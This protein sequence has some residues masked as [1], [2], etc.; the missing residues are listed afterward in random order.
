IITAPEP[1][2]LVTS[3]AIA[4]IADLET[5]LYEAPFVQKVVSI[6]D[7]IALMHQRLF[8]TPDG[9][10][11]TA[12][13]APAQYMLLYEAS[14]DPGDFDQEIDYDYQ[15]ALVR[16]Q[17]DRDHYSEVRDSVDAFN[18]IA[19]DWS[20]ESGL[21][22]R[23]SGR[24][25][26]NDGW[27]TSLAQGHGVSLGLA[28]AF[29]FTATL[30][31]Y[32]DARLSLITLAPVLSGV[33]L[34]YA[35]MGLLGIAIAPATSM[36]AAI[37]TG[38]GVDFGVHLVQEIRRKLAAGGDIADAVGEQYVLIARACAYCAASLA[39]G[40][41]VVILSGVPVLRWFGILVASATVGSLL[42]ALFVVPALS[43]LLLNRRAT[44]VHA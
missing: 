27:M 22:A 44:P 43:S 23:V 21:T 33:A 18:D 24:L 36:C 19:A 17:L 28:V 29:V 31:L 11:P 13:N 1:E 6:A 32:R 2:G 30:A 34:V 15:R 41:L 8:D 20:E 25:A 7:Y 9:A 14:G 16:A 10:L 42:G 35:M 3:A 39:V 5:R 4:A 38:L 40:F 12:P 37:A 26:V